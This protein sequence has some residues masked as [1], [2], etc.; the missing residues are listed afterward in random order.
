[1]VML[2]NGVSVMAQASENSEQ[3]V[4]IIGDNGDVA[5]R[6][7]AAVRNWRAWVALWRIPRKSIGATHIGASNNNSR[8][9][10][11]RANA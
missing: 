10:S 8:I 3:V 6:K 1:M 5:E 4:A 7:E 9:T 11:S 2:K